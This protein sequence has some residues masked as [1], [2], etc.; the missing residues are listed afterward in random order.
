MKSRKKFKDSEI[1]ELIKFKDDKDM[2][3][4][5]I[6]DHDINL[7]PLAKS[8]KWPQIS[9]LPVEFFEDLKS[10]RPV[11]SRYYLF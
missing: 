8:M 6:W 10:K 11:N 7:T 2:I 3:K 1:E 4:K 9:L 5:F